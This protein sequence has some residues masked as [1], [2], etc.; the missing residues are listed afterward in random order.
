[1]AWRRKVIAMKVE[2]V[3]TR[4]VITCSPADKLRDIVQLMSKNSISGLPV[5]DDG[6]LVGIVT[7][8]DIAKILAG[9]PASST[10]WLPSP[11]EVLLEIPIKDLIELRR[12]QQSVKDV[13]EKPV[14]DVMSRNPITIEPENDIEDASALL[15]RYKINRL[16]VVKS[17]KLVGIVTRDDIIQGLGGAE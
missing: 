15:V 6:K 4:D 3:M 10:L 11:F 17:G 16:P 12:L 13:G 2:E 7:E 5:V 14:S 1:V 9:P 8:G